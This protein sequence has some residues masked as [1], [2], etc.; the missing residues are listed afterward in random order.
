MKRRFILK[1]GFLGRK[2]IMIAALLFS[3]YLLSADPVDPVDL[4]MR[5][6]DPVTHQVEIVMRPTT[7]ILATDIISEIRYT[8]LW[9][10]PLLV[11]TDGPQIAPF[12][13]QPQGGPVPSGG[14]YYQTYISQ[15]NVPVGYAINAG[16]EVVIATFTVTAPIW[17]MIFLTNDQYMLDHNIQYFYELGGIDRTGEI[18]CE[19]VQITPDLSV[20]LSD[21]SVYLAIFLMAGAVVVSLIRR[22]W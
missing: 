12:S 5:L 2:M 11:I 4:C 7:T 19:S 18:I 3:G 21:W 14:V 10:Q 17:S 20:P 13:L 16:Q 15:P 8:I 9:Q 6:A 22:P 1:N